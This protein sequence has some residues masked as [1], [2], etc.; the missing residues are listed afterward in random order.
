MHRTTPIARTILLLTTTLLLLALPRA[1]HAGSYWW[2]GTPSAGAN[3]F[4]WEQSGG[5]NPWGGGNRCETAPAT[6]PT[7]GYCNLRW[8]VPAGLDA[9]AGSISGSYRHNN[10]AF[11]QRNIVDGAGVTTLQ[12]DSTVRAY[13]RQWPG[14]G[15]WL[16]IQLLNA[17]TPQTVSGG[18][19][20]FDAGSFTINL[21]DPHA[22]HDPP[23]R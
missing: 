8:T 5:Y 16:A 23:V 2:T 22:P 12:G 1:A 18:T 19:Q 11:E 3:G 21:V 9:L 17:S 10:A 15:G 20:W 6:I 13:T 7:S 4:S 14:M